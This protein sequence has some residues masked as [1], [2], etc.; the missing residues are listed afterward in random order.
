VEVDEIDLCRYDS[1][2]L[3]RDSVEGDVCHENCSL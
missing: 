2:L 3:S 1:L